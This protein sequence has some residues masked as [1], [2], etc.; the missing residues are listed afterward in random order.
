MFDLRGTSP[1]K[2]HARIFALEDVSTAV[3]FFLSVGNAACGVI[4]D[5]G[6]GIADG[7][8]YAWDIINPF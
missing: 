5:I 6:G 8:S 7:A 3:N 4:E 2:A 1:I